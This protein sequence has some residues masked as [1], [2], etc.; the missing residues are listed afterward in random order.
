MKNC[1]ECGGK[2][3]GRSDKKFCNDNCRNSFNNALNKDDTN[4]MRNI[5]NRL[6]KNYRILKKLNTVGTTKVQRK[7]MFQNG[8]DF[9]LFTSIYQTQTGTLYWFVYNQGY[10]KIDDN[11]YFLISKA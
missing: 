9:E 5:N 6:R 2:L 1:L 11:W 4:L 3:T 7:K 10:S 8:F